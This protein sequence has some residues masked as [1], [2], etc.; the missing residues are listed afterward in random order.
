MP[1]A[2]WQLYDVVLCWSFH[3]YQDSRRRILTHLQ[4]GDICLA[5]VQHHWQRKSKKT[6]SETQSR[7]NTTNL[8]QFKYWWLH[9]E[10][11][12]YR[13]RDGIRQGGSRRLGTME[14]KQ[15][16]PRLLGVRADTGEVS[17]C[18]NIQ[19]QGVVSGSGTSIPAHERWLGNNIEPRAPRNICQSID[20][21]RQSTRPAMN[22]S[23]N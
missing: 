7:C 5:T 20:A 19:L 16:K 4:K 14:Q 21:V 18:Q 1:T 23:T 22:A 2:T 17:K 11:R 13:S 15:S 6:S 3:Q 10:P 12:Q 8:R 9:A